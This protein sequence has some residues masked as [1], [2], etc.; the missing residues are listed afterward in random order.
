MSSRVRWSGSADC[1]GAGSRSTVVDRDRRLCTRDVAVEVLKPERKL[2][3]VE[4][5]RSSTELRALQVL[6][7]EPKTLDLGPCL[8]KLGSVPTA[9]VARMSM[10]SSRM[11]PRGKNLHIAR[12]RFRM[13]LRGDHHPELAA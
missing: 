13:G 1:R 8:R 6:N 10:A 7:D 4:P 2:V 9:C 5:F 11:C 12:R 3:A